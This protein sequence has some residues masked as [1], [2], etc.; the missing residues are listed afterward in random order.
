MF[1]PMAVALISVAAAAQETR[2]AKGTA[3]TVTGKVIDENGEPLPGAYVLISGTKNGTSTDADGR[4]SI[5][6]KQ[7][8]Q[9]EIQFL[10]YGSSTVHA[11]SKPLTIRL[12]PDK[13]LYLEEAV[14]IA[15]G[16]VQK[17]DLTGSVANVKMADIKNSPSLSVDQALQGRIAGADFMT[18]TGEPGATTTIRIRGTRSIIASNEPLI[19]VDGVMDAVSD[20][21]D[22]NSADIESIT[23]LKDASSTAIYGS[24]GSNGVIL[25]TTKKGISSAG[26]PKITF[27]AEAGFGQLPSNLDLMN[28][29]ELAQYRN[30]LSYFTGLFSEVSEG[31][32]LSDYRYKDPLSLGEGTN[33]I[34]EITRIA[35]VQ[36]YALSASGGGKQSSWYASFGY[37]D[38]R[39]IIKN[40]GMSR[41]T[42]RL[43]LDHQLFKWLKVGYQGS[44]SYRDQDKNLASIGGTSYRNSAI[45]LSPLLKPNDYI[46]E[47]YED[48][49]T[50]N[51]P[52]ATIAQNTYNLTRVS[53]NHTVY[54]EF[55]FTKNLK[56]RS[57]NTYYNYQNHTYRYYPSTLP[58]KNQGEGGD[59]Y[60]A[61]S[62]AT[63]LSSENTLDW[64][65]SKKGH[66]LDLLGGY[67]A[68]KAVTNSLSISGSGYMD[69]AVKW[70][71]LGGVIDKNTLSPS[72]G[73]S[74]VFKMSAF[75]R[76][77]YNYR[78]RYYITMTGRFD[79]ASNFAANNKWGFFPSVAVKWNAKNEKFLK[80]ASR[81]DELSLRLSAGRT[82]NDAVAAYRSIEK[83]T[84]TTG[85][86]LFNGSQQASYYRI[87][88]PS[89]DLTWEKTDL[90]N[91]ALD[92]SFFNNRLAITAEGYISK[93]KDLLMEVQVASQSGFNSK[94][95]NLGNT[96]N[97]GMELTIESRNIVKKNFTW[98]T[99]LT[100][101]RNVQRVDDIGTSE[102]IPT[103]TSDG[104]NPYMMH[105][106]V[107]GY[108]LNALWGFKYAGVWHSVDEFVRN[109]TTHAYVSESTIPSE[110]YS[111]R[112][113]LP[114]YY[115]INNDGLLDQN[116]LVYLGNADPDLYGGFQNTFNIYGLNLGVYLSW[117]LGGKIYNYSELYMAGGNKTNQYKYMANR[118]HP[119]RNPDGDLPRAGGT[120]TVSIPSDRMVY[121]ASYLRLKSVSIGYTFDLSKKTSWLRDIT[122]TAS[123]ENLYLWKKYNG[124]DP[125]VS[126]SG[127]S[128]TLRRLDLGAYPKARTIVFS[129]QIRY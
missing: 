13:S 58:A 2:E 85:G 42:G 95:T 72:S 114:K 76:F 120:N 90:Y 115:D 37:N 48:A 7:T 126:S 35:P 59:A 20:L 40:S 102:F 106:F 26:K 125:D 122:L 27:K 23:V 10:G 29:S 36:N 45:Y 53:M 63:N 98:T 127:D 89:P 39:G 99:N 84:S 80:N 107:K 5:T 67:T 60:R 65:F 78:K 110:Y 97:K 46:D 79:G 50:F 113:G 17:Q 101:S 6:A 75:A 4:F 117:S 86:Y 51:P 103:A 57:Q 112:L 96:T 12:M 71:N 82:G 128:S 88:I 24:R 33:W 116:D 41:Y 91:L 69:D 123:G 3:I 44:F 83:L 94:F 81:I 111:S 119:V 77:D 38:T 11:S 43:N 100:L 52:T 31:S 21:N 8:D 68:Y 34:K 87:S 47:E 70:N 32:P 28:A 9:L 1:I 93:T 62:E 121:D 56:L 118:W 16:S 54:L 49:A 14:T 66:T 92:M 25:I 104:N 129:V 19:V 18:T 61:E 108:P 55:N 73:H 74:E 64:K 105:G 109:E 15:Y 22:V 124:F 30:D